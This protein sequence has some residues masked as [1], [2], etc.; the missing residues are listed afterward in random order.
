MVNK[1]R[2]KEII[3]SNEEFILTKIKK[4]VK[5]E[6]I[7]LPEELNKVVVFYGVRRS[8]K[9]FILFDLF[10]KISECSVYIDFEDERLADFQAEELEKV[11]EAILE[12]KPHLIDREIVFL[13][14]EIQ[15]V[16]GWEK[17]CRRAVERGEH[18]NLRKRL[19]I[20]DD[21]FRNTYGIK[22]TIME[23]GGISFL[24]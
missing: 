24:F 15:N 18:K 1:S 21:A 5:R 19:F 2:L 7:Y 3:L 17:F 6:I 22:R 4:I 10:R 13:L 8:G 20:K 11:K 9:T 14:D 16:K 23:R 12:L